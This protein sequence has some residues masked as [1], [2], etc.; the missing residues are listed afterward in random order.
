MTRKKKPE[1]KHKKW[2]YDKKIEEVQDIGRPSKMSKSVVEKL[3]KCFSNSYTDEEACLFV[4]IDKETLYTYC[5]K[6]PAFSI[7]KE[8]LKKKPNLK[9]KNVVLEAINNNDVQSAKWWLE[10]KAKDEFSS[11]NEVTGEDGNPIETNISIEVI[12]VASRESEA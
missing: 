1:E 5:D 11:R 9:A 8:L 2:N 4:G 7:N 12:G 10:K 3:E 6:Y